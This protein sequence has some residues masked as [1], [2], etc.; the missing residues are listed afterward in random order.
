MSSIKYQNS[1]RKKRDEFL[2]GIVNQFIQSDE[3]QTIFDCYDYAKIIAETT[4]QSFIDN[5]TEEE[6]TLVVINTKAWFLPIESIRTFVVFL[7]N[8]EI[9]LNQ[10]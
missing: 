4:I 8:N 5:L 6:R 9:T 1:I 7:S 10:I 2:I 3:N